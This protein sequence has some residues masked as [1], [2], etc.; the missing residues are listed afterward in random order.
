MAHKKGQ[1]VAI[2]VKKIPK[3]KT[4]TAKPAKKSSYKKYKNT[5]I[6]YLTCV[7]ILYI[8]IYII[9]IYLPI[10][11]HVFTFTTSKNPIFTILSL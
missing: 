1:K 2:N 8:L 10:K 7:Y 11:Q 6:L 9:I 3:K 4:N 5:L